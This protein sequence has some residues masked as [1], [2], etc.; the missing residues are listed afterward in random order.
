MSL[1]PEESDVEGI[2]MRCGKREEDEWPQG[3]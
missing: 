3:E 2:K 1:P